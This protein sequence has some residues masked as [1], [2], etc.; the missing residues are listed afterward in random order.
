MSSSSGT[1][2]TTV[3]S[4]TIALILDVSI[5]LYIKKRYDD[6]AKAAQEVYATNLQK[7]KDL[8]EKERL[9]R[10]SVQK[11]TRDRL[12]GENLKLGYQYRPIGFVETGEVLRD[13]QFWSLQHWGKLGSTKA[14]F[15]LNTSKRLSNSVIFGSFSYFTRTLTVILMHA[16]YQHVLN[17]LGSVARKS[18][19]FLRALLIALMLLVCPYVRWWRLAAILSV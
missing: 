3:F 5:L 8:R 10:I 11:K 12:N 6:D 9:G 1:H 15:S 13:S 2:L 19:V 14:L 7:E 17:R 4:I 16:K 18:D